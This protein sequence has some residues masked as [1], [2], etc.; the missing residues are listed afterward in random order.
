LT[1]NRGDDM[2]D[3]GAKL[4]RHDLGVTLENAGKSLT[5]HVTLTLPLQPAGPVP[6]VVQGGFGRAGFGGRGNP[7]AKTK[8]GPR[9]NRL[10]L[11]TER[12][13]AV[14]EFPFQEAAVDNKDRARTAGVYPL[15]GADIDCG[16]LMAWAWGIHRVIDALETDAR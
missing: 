12:G 14:A 13:Y 5:L 1:V 7:P 9:P 10:S 16:A 4:A 6:V 15:F 3:E 2:V 8:L 11:F